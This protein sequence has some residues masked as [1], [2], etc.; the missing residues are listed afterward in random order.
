MFENID[1]ISYYDKT[2]VDTLLTNTNLTGSENI[3][4]TNNQIPLTFPL[5]VN[6]EIVINP[7]ACGIQ[8]ELYAATSG[9]AFFTK[10]TRW[11]TTNSDFQLIR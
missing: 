1:L 3:D 7:R 10:P 8:F 11:C 6:E 9:F 4:I 2:E 5:K